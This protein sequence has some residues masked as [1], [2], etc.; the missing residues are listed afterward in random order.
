MLLD[1]LLRYGYGM[2]FVAAAVEGDATL[3]TATFLAHRGY[4]QLDW[5]IAV[6][7]TA[8]VAVN[9]VYF[10]LA[11]TYGQ[12]RS[13]T[14]CE[15]PAYGRVF[16]WVTRYGWQLVIASRFIY[17]F[18]IAIPMVCGAIGLQPVRF[19]VGDIIGSALWATTVGLAGYA[20]GQALEYVIDDVRRH[21]WW[22]AIGLLVVGL[23]ILAWRGRDRP[24]VLLRGTTLMDAGPKG[25]GKT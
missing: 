24:L 13:A 21:E 2:V 22:I 14:L 15:H 3:L 10:W 23:A 4:L 7:A 1:L 18:R 11:R 16:G 25:P 6:A 17:G 5:V 8:T 20:I 9:Q 19:L 12:D